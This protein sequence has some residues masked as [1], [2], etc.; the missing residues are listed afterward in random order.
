M[1]AGYSS[2]VRETRIASTGSQPYCR[3]S[4]CGPLMACS[5]RCVV[6][7]GSSV[8]LTNSWSLLPP[9]SV[10]LSICQV[11]TVVKRSR[12]AA[13][14]SQS[15][16]VIGCH[17][18]CQVN[19]PVGIADA[20]VPTLAPN[21]NRWSKRLKKATYHGSAFAMASCVNAG[22]ESTKILCG[23]AA[24]SSRQNHEPPDRLMKRSAPAA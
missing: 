3:S 23:M 11:I 19:S 2:G 12:G 5:N 1:K 22:S 4:C 14:V 17:V 8:D 9:T 24:Y 7:D 21:V 6:F 18:L 16:I 10:K 13:A 20:A 15:A